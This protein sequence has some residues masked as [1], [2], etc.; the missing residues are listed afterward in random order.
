MAVHNMPPYS[1]VRIIDTYLTARRFFGFTSN[2]LAWLSKYLAPSKKSDHREFPGIELWIECL[3]DN[4][5]AWRA[6][7]LYNAQDVVSDE[8]V[9]LRIRPWIENH[10][11]L[12]TY[13]DSDVA[14]CPKC[15]STRLLSNGYRVNQTGRYRRL[16]CQACGGWAFEKARGKLLG[17]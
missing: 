10:P 8:Q 15:T 13:T 4:P 3:K 17:N 5:R 12:V 16:Q 6:M 7:R 14:R 2:K 9:Y 11:N 1:P